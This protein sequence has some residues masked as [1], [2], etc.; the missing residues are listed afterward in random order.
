MVDSIGMKNKKERRRR[1][2]VPL[3]GLA[4]VTSGKNMLIASA[5]NIAA[6]G[7]SVVVP[8]RVGNG[9][10]VSV[11]FSLPDAEE[12]FLIKATVAR[13]TE[14]PDGFQLGM[15]F[16]SFEGKVLVHVQEFVREQLVKMV[17]KKQQGAPE[18]T[19][20]AKP[21]LPKAFRKVRQAHELEDYKP[22]KMVIDLDGSEKAADVAQM[23]EDAWKEAGKKKK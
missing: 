23:F 12:S 6:E 20:H 22:T 8:E 1:T 15:R 16:D 2:R 13:V 9:S 4:V 17:K 18:K 3:S 21:P 11:E 14:I 7:I 19:D 10:K 5:M